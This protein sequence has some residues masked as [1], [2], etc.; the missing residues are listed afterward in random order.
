MSLE[1]INTLMPEEFWKSVTA[2]IKSLSQEHK[3][4]TIFIHGYNVSFEEAAIQTA[5]MLSDINM[6]GI[7][8]FYSWPSQGTLLGYS[9]DESTIIAS[10]K[11]ISEF[12]GSFTS[13]PEIE[14]INIIAHSMGNRGVLDAFERFLKQN[15]LASGKKVNQI[16]LAAPDVDSDVFDQFYE[17]YP[18]TSQR[19]TIYVSDKDRAL[20]ASGALHLFKRTGLTPPITIL[21]GIDT[22]FVGNIDLSLLGHGYVANNRVVLTDI[23]QLLLNNSAPC[24]RMGLKMRTTENGD[25]YEIQK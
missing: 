16:I 5:Q 17:V 7:F 15:F 24:Q 10:F 14:K 1:H 9:A 13:I 4:A 11:Y 22:V 12:I 8:A 25:Y 21:K 23:H 20:Q 19:T 6:P 2:A 3:S 18:L